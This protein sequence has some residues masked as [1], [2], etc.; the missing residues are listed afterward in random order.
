MSPVDVASAQLQLKVAPCALSEPLQLRRLA[1]TTA[2]SSHHLPSGA[3]RP[4]TVV[5]RPDGAH[6]VPVL[7]RVAG[8]AKPTKQQQ[9]FSQKSHDDA[10]PRRPAADVPAPSR[11]LSV[12]SVFGMQNFGPRGPLLKSVPT[13]WNSSSSCSSPEE[14]ESTAQNETDH[15]LPNSDDDSGSSS[16][17][18]EPG[19]RSGS[20]VGWCTAVG[21]DQEFLSWDEHVQHQKNV[22]C[23]AFR[24]YLCSYCLDCVSMYPHMRRHETVGDRFQCQICSAKFVD[25]KSLHRH[26]IRFHRLEE[27]HSTN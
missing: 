8:P 13:S 10:T 4:C 3:S 6:L 24:S 2:L 23:I 16:K 18:F 9:H 27:D 25:F 1:E 21:C 12:K 5:I 7:K 20:P 22:H 14:L 19:E 15:Q 11:R 26:G 17:T